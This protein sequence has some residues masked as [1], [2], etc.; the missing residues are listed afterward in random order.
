MGS[1]RYAIR[2]DWMRNSHCFGCLSATPT[3]V[4]Q[5]D[6]LGEGWFAVGSFRRQIPLRGLIL[7]DGKTP[8]GPCDFFPRRDL[9]VRN[10]SPH[11]HFQVSIFPWDHFPTALSRSAAALSIPVETC[12]ITSATI[13]ICSS[14]SF[15]FFSSM[16]SRTA[17]TG[18][19]P[20]PV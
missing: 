16:N 18:L 10:I 3:T 13:G 15:H 1:R 5:S 17:A 11:R 4:L 12:S 8:L 9:G 2:A 14:A 19:A 20:Y 7:R 6:S